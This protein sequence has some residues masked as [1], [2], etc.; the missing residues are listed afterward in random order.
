MMRITPA[1]QRRI[2]ELGPFI[3]RVMKAIGEAC[4]EPAIALSFVTDESR[5]GHFLEIGENPMRIRRRGGSPQWRD[6]PANPEVLQRNDR[7][8]RVV[9][10]LLGMPVS[11]ADFVHEVAERL[12]G[13][14]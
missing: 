2:A 6:L 8:L 7:A 9:A 11:R 5:V 14:S 4:S 10:E 3:T 12:K 13:K 1:S